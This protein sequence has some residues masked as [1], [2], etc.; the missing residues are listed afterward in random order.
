M[1]VAKQAA[2]RWPEDTSFEAFLATLP[3]N[4]DNV[5]QFFFEA[6]RDRIKVRSEA[7][8][9]PKLKLIVQAIFDIS[10]HRG[11]HAM[12]TRD[13]CDATGISMGGV[14]N[15]IGSKDQFSS[16]LIAFVGQTFTEINRVLLPPGEARHARLEAHVR[17]QVYMT[18]LFRPWYFFVFMETKN[19]PAEQKG[20]V[21][22]VERRLVDSLASMIEEGVAAGDYDCAAPKLVAATVLAVVDDWYL[23]PWYFRSA[24]TD[25]EAYA[26]YVVDALNRLIGNR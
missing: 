1:E 12:S 20:Q 23:K 18:E 11:F 13:L 5:Y 17:A 25:V 16:M 7:Q 4:E 9:L 21:K 14:Y 3:L 19:A 15:Y 2:A 22:D 6:N 24:G 10:A 26:D 8:A